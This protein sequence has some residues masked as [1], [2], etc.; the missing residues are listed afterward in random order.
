M[1]NFLHKLHSSIPTQIV[2]GQRRGI[3]SMSNFIYTLLIFPC[4]FWAISSKIN[5]NSLIPNVWEDRNCVDSHKIMRRIAINFIRWIQ[6]VV[7]FTG[8]SKNSFVCFYNE[9]PV[10]FY[11]QIH[12]TGVDFNWMLPLLIVS[13]L[14]FKRFNREFQQHQEF[15]V[16]S[17]DFHPKSANH[18]TFCFEQIEI[19]WSLK[20]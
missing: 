6:Q 12:L 16:I 10:K 11:W 17:A 14:N 15:W 8:Q 1:R 4:I 2:K 5:F 20:K 18:H 9:G 7:S 13:F 3:V 19:S